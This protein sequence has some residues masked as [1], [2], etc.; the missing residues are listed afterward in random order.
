[1]VQFV[2]KAL[3]E[4]DI[5]PKEIPFSQSTIRMGNIISEI[6]NMLKLVKDLSNEG[7]DRRICPFKNGMTCS[8]VCVFYDDVDGYQEPHTNMVYVKAEICTLADIAIRGWIEE[9]Q[10]ET[11]PAEEVANG[12]DV[13][14]KIKDFSVEKKMEVAKRLHKNMQESVGLLGKKE[15]TKKKRG[16]PKRK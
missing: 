5:P 14:E 2:E 8:K 1:M 3:L 6:N 12:F 4:T 9:K 13:D 16:R 10:I 7:P 15:T 11:F